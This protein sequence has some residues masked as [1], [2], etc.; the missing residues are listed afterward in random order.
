MKLFDKVMIAAGLGI[1]GYWCWDKLSKKLSKARSISALQTARRQ[2]RCCAKV[3]S[4][5]RVQGRDRR[6]ELQVLR[7][8][9]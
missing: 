4:R 1:I 2:L 6:D 8:R 3:T 7:Y 9:P 5:R